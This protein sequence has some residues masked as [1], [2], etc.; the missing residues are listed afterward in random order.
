MGLHTVTARCQRE[1][2][3]RNGRKILVVDTPGFFGT[4]C[5]WQE[6]AAEVK[7][8]AQLCLPGPH[9]IIHVVKI[10]VFTGEEK[11]VIRFIKA[12]FQ[13]KAKAYLIILFTRKEDLEGKSLESFVSAQGEELRKYIAECGNRCLA[14]SN[15]AQEAERE[16]QVEKLI[17]MI[18]DLVEKNQDAPYYSEG[19]QKESSWRFSLF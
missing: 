15:K 14:F 8:C 7:K 1:E 10:G 9:A 11:E 3:L 2:T 16:A 19:T 6:T 17:Q 4:R 12:I 13:S 18:D 5:S